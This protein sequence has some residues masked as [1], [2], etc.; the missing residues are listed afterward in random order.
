MMQLAWD[1]LIWLLLAAGVA[2]GAL[3]F[4]GLLI[5]PDIRSRMFTAI[6]AT[7]ISVTVI[8]LAVILFG[9]NGFLATGESQYVTLIIHI[10]FF[11]GVV[12]IANV[13]ISR[14]ILDR[15]SP[16]SCCQVIPEA[17]AES[18]PEKKD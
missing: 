9:V 13:S 16:V 4:F 11:F 3:G 12:V 1:L 15:T 6:R 2:F 10:I 8:A 18:G 14:I 17:G 5:F 7:L